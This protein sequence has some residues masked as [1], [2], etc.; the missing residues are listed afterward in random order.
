MRVIG[1]GGGGGFV[2]LSSAAWG[3]SG[4]SPGWTKEIGFYLSLVGLVGMYGC[5][6]R[7]KENI[8]PPLME[9]PP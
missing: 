2:S 5:C 3:R 4:R 7:K 1:G 6:C 8:T 9:T